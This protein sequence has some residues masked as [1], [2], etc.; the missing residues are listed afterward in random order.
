MKEYKT[1]K[2]LT[3]R[4][5]KF[6]EYEIIGET[7][8]DFHVWDDKRHRI[9]INKANLRGNYSVTDRQ[10]PFGKTKLILQ[11]QQ[12]KQDYTKIINAIKKLPPDD[13]DAVEYKL[14]QEDGIYKVVGVVSYIDGAGQYQEEEQVVL[15]IK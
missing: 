10:V 1:L 6:E 15:E 4:G 13:T 2:I 7:K 8:T 9:V 12:S 14:I 3:I 11:L 5:E